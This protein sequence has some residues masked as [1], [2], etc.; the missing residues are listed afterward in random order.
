MGR[1]I[2]MEN[3]QNDFN[4]RLKLVE[5]ALEEIIKKVDDLSKNNTSVHHVDLHEKELEEELEETVE[6]DE[7]EKVSA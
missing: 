4:R 6:E 5:G 3:R 1:A 2:E 7:K